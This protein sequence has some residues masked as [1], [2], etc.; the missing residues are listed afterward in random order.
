MTQRGAHQY[1]F[2]FKKYLK[3]CSLCSSLVNK[4][5][6]LQGRACMTAGHFTAE[7]ESTEKMHGGAVDAKVIRASFAL[8]VN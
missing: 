2:H 7:T 3:K 5:G 8:D 4:V 6:Y 1:F